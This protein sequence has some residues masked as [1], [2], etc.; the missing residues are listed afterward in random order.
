MSE[1]RY[2]ITDRK[3]LGGIEPLLRTIAAAIQ[4]GVT[5][6]QIRERDLTARDLLSLARQAVALGGRILINDRADIALAAGAQGVHLPADSI[7]PAQLRA[8]VPPGFLIAV[9]CHSIE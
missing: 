4:D 8:I 5:H 6:I 2:Y 7:S 9:S 1:M 3:P